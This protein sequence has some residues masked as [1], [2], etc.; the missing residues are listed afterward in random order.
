MNYSNSPVIG[1]MPPI[2]HDAYP[3]FIAS[4]V[5][6]GAVVFVHARLRIGKGGVLLF[7]AALY[8]HKRF[9]KPKRLP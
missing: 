4:I 6:F 2:P 5:I 7:W 3:Y 9:F 1:I 8:A